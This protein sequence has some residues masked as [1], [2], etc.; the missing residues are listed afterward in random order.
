MAEVVP[1]TLTPQRALTLIR[2]LSADSGNV[3]VVA[4]GRRRQRQRSISFKQ[5][6]ACLRK[7]T[8]GEGPYRTATG[9]WR[10]NVL[11]HAAGEEITCVVEFDWPQR[12][13]IVTVF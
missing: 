13:L 6:V 12:L 5:I 3:V 7:G 10:C 1:L 4:H 11:R 2:T 9:A 8:I